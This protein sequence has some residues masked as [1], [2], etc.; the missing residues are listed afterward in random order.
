METRDRMEKLRSD[1]AAAESRPLG[2]SSPHDALG[3]AAQ[4]GV[5]PAQFMTI[6]TE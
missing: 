5:I 1:L 4:R 6:I 2:P 3:V